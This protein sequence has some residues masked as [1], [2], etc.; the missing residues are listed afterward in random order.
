MFEESVFEIVSLSEQ[1]RAFGGQRAWPLPSL[2]RGDFDTRTELAL[3]QPPADE[4]NVYAE[5]V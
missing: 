3:R 4:L 2:F 1:P 5:I